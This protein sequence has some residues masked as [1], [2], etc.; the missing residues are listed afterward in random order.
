LALL[1][2]AGLGVGGVAIVLGVRAFVVKEFRL[3]RRRLLKGRAAELAGL[4]AVL[5]GVALIGYVV[6][7]VKAF[8]EGLGH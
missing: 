8:P 4:V 5:A 3:T 7:M 2:L 6:V 1:P